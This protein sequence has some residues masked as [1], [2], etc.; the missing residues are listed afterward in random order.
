MACLPM[1]AD[2]HH[3]RW[4]RQGWHEPSAKEVM[5][6]FQDY[7]HVCEACLGTVAEL[8]SAAV[9]YAPVV[10][11]AQVTRDVEQQYT[12][13][14]QALQT[15]LSALP[16]PKDTPK[17]QHAQLRKQ[18]TQLQQELH[19]LVKAQEAA[20]T[21]QAKKGANAR[22]K[23]D[24][25]VKTVRG[26]PDT[27]LRTIG[28]ASVEVLPRMLWIYEYDRQGDDAWRAAKREAKRFVRQVR[29]ASAPPVASAAPP[30]T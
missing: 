8:A 14:I 10:N 20:I 2:R 27:V 3:E 11:A 1:W 25:L 18:K 26:Y 13:Q 22:H 23:L 4:S 30:E 29:Q 15:Q 28:K 7:L 6:L 9:A 17:A 12:E 21:R 5:A 19:T 16:L 24:T